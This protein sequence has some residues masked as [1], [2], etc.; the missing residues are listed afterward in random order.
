MKASSASSRRARSRSP[1]SADAGLRQ[2]FTNFRFRVAVE[3]LSSTGAVGV[4]FPTAR[5]VTVA[6]KRRVVQFDPLVI[7]RGLTL[8]TEWY[9]WW[10]QVRRSSRAP[11]RDVQVILLD[12]NGVDALRWVYPDSM[13]LSYSLSPLNALVGEALIESLELRVGEFDL[14]RAE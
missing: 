14:Y 3:G 10:N 8:S 9:D 11:R 7:R 4:V 1:R 5:I 2:P 12:S 6:R 13:P